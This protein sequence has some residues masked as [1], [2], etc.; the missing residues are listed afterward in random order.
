MSTFFWIYTMTVWNQ[1]ANWKLSF[2]D[3]E[4]VQ[5]FD[6]LLHFCGCQ[7]FFGSNVTFMVIQGISDSSFNKS[8][9]IVR[10]LLVTWVL[11]LPLDVTYALFVQWYL[12]VQTDQ[13]W[14]LNNPETR[15]TSTYWWKVPVIFFYVIVSILILAKPW[16]FIVIGAVHCYIQ[17]GDVYWRGCLNSLPQIKVAVVAGKWF[18]AFHIWS[19]H[20][21]SNLMKILC[22]R[23]GDLN[24]WIIE[25]IRCH[26]IKMWVVLWLLDRD[27]GQ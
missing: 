10:I 17:N 25:I 5:K 19:P 9:V 2:L 11:F 18:Y 16:M 23:M 13:Y 15:K 6:L 26:A 7:L 12:P 14:P 27:T 8:R 1:Y 20:Y 21:W 3:Q 24:S 22:G 4:I